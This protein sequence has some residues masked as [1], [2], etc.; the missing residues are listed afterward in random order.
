MLR[1]LLLP[2]QREGLSGKAEA[3]SKFK[4]LFFK[5]YIIYI[6]PAYEFTA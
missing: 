2:K 1:I 3:L 4:S 5:D 6:L